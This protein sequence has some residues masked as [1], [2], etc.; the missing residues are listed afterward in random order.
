MDIHEA[1]NSAIEE[2]KRAYSVINQGKSSQ[3]R[4][5]ELKQ[6]IKS[7][8]YSWKKYYPFIVKDSSIQDLQSIDAEYTKILEATEKNASKNT[9]LIS[10][11]NLKNHLIKLR[12]EVFMG[13]L[14]GG[15]ATQIIDSVPDFTPL[16]SDEIMRGILAR[17]WEE[18]KRCLS[19]EAPLSAAVMMG[20]LLESLFVSKANK[21]TD[22]TTLFKTKSAPLDFKTKKPLNL[23]EWTLGSYIDVGQELGWISKIGKDVADVLRNY[24]NYIH[25]EKER[26]HGVVLRPEDA[27]ILWSITKSLTSQLLK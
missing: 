5:K 14:S 22:K 8:V 2:I 20:G 18:C 1:L 21:M 10:L 19:A 4:T 17:R 16:A 23:K 13:D 12:S 25:P 27:K 15:G 24:R 7:V 3:I 26:S 6:Y 11:E 9:Y